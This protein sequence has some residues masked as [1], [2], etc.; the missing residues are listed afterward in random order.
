MDHDPWGIDISILIGRAAFIKKKNMSYKFPTLTP[1]ELNTLQHSLGLNKYGQGEA[2]R[3]HYCSSPEGPDADL[4]LALVEK[5]F[6]VERK[7]SFIGD[8]RAF[9]V[10]A[11]GET[12]CRSQ[13]PQAPKLTRSQMRYQRFLNSDTAMSFKEWFKIDT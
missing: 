13:S 8:L 3:R 9:I 4:C 7:V 2:Y 6:M 12:A 1:E 11:D 5:G 10:T